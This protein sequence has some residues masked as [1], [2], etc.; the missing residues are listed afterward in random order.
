[1][2]PDLCHHCI[3]AVFYSMCQHLEDRITA[4]ERRVSHTEAAVTIPSGG[5]PINRGSNDYADIGPG[6]EGSAM[7]GHTLGVTVG[8]AVRANDQVSSE[9]A[10]TTLDVFLICKQSFEEPLEGA[11]EKSFTPTV[12]TVN[13]SRDKLR[14]REM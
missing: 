10:S 4:L 5:G 8:E 9:A 1:M 12:A 3:S 13:R 11:K 7:G 2:F 6:V 14:C